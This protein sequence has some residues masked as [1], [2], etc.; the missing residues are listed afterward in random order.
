[1]KSVRGIV[2]CG[3][4]SLAGSL[5]A[6][7]PAWAQVS[8]PSIQYGQTIVHRG[9]PRSSNASITPNAAAGTATNQFLGLVRFP[10][11]LGGNAR[12]QPSVNW[13]AQ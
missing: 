8:G 4:L 11:E 5:L 12:S 9:Q 1:M 13:A 6:A 3:M 2:A 10:A 7:A